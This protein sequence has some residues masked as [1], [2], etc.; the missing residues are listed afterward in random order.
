MYTK[1]VVRATKKNGFIFCNREVIFISEAII[2]ARIS[3]KSEGR[4]DRRNG[5]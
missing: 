3:G 1:A 4:G 2:M 5:R